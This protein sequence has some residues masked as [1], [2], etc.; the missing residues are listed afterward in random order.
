MFVD[1]ACRA[2][3]PRFGVYPCNCRDVGDTS[4]RQHPLHVVFVI[5][6]RLITRTRST[7]SVSYA[8]MKLCHEV[9]SPMSPTAPTAPTVPTAPTS[10]TSPLT[11]VPSNALRR[12]GDEEDWRM[13]LAFCKPRHNAVTTIEYVNCISQTWRMKERVRNLR[14]VDRNSD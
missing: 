3:N 1:V 13:Q 9:S 2:C 12:A 5:T 7:M 4:Q 6:T 8:R 11:I 14:K 10:P